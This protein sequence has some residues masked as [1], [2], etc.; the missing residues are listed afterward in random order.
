MDRTDWAFGETEEEA[1][2]E[3]KEMYGDDEEETGDD[4]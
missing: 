1:V 3:C 2:R 4:V